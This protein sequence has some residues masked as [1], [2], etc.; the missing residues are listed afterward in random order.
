VVLEAGD[1]RGDLQPH[2]VAACVNGRE[3]IHGECRMQNSECR[4]V[5]ARAPELH[6]A[7]YILHSALQ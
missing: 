2:R 6:S 7:F 5:K 3:E 1:E 4:I